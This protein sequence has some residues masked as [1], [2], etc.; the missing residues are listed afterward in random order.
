MINKETKIFI[1]VSKYPG[2]TGSI[3][4][5]TG[6]KMLNLNCVYIPLKCEGDKDLKLILNNKNFNGISVS[7][8]FKTKVIKFLKK[9]DN[10]AKKSGAVNTIL[11]KKQ[12][13]LVGYNTDYY[14]LKKIIKSKKLK[15]KNCLLLGNGS[16]SRTTYEVL[17][18]LKIKIV[19]LCSR[20][21]KNYKK[22]KIRKSDRI[23][24][25]ENRNFLNSDLLINCT[26]LGMK[27]INVI[28]KKLKNKKQHKYIIDFTINNKNKLSKS[29]KK[30]GITYISGLEI[31]FNQ[32]LEQFR[33]YNNKILS[34]K[35]LKK[36]L[37]YNF[38]V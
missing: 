33:I 25:W 14:A 6:Y 24:N 1:S 11:R 23:I 27:H 17:K 37:N 3:L 8:P 15:I 4:H 5:N 21:K 12:N 16:T 2:N 34:F 19:N 28:P 10:S 20:R 9:I 35:K 31:S 22:W 18:D 26:P 36:K 38:N 32:G 30:F 29:A 13:Y 7:M